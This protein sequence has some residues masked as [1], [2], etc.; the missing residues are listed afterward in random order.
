[1]SLFYK[2]N[3]GR[4][5]K[6][7]AARPAVNFR[8]LSLGVHGSAHVDRPLF[9][10]SWG[11]AGWRRGFADGYS[12]RLKK[13]WVA[14]RCVCVCPRRTAK[15][16][17]SCMKA[18]DLELRA[19]S[20]IRHRGGSLHPVKYFIIHHNYDPETQDEDIA[21]VKVKKPFSDNPLVR[22]IALPKQNE[23]VKPNI[24]AIVVGWGSTG[25]DLPGSSFLKDVKVEIMDQN[26]CRDTDAFSY[27]HSITKN[28]I[29]AASFLKDTR[30]GDSG[31]P[32][33]IGR[34]SPKLV[35]IT[36]WGEG[37]GDLQS[38]GVYTR[39]A[40]YRNWIRMKTGL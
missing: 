11:G 19:G 40:K 7:R 4:D 25:V 37:T 39:V 35:G 13:I 2:I 22:Y 27:T 28:M 18:K 17:Q 9:I 5:F 1:M 21:L 10:L 26:R 34:N 8:A 29:C 14:R 23:A 38:P 20:V 6:S 24:K 36:S 16:R 32:M 3:Q 15:W 30:T 12:S 31:G 33:I